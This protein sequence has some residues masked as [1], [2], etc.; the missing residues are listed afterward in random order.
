MALKYHPNIGTIVICDFKGFKQPE[1][2][3]RRPAV[4]ISPKLKERD[5]RVCTIVACSTVEPNPIANFHCKIDINPPL[6]KPYN[7]PFQWIKGDMI[8]AVSVERLFFPIIGKDINGKRIYDV[9][10]LKNDD[11]KRVQMCVLNSLNFF[12]LTKYI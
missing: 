8:M 2:T 10:V 9:R 7:S 4:V 3:K 1:M 12:S 5:N 6:P 11:L